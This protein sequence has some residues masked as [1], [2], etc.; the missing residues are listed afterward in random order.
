MKK[1]LI[2]ISV[3]WFSALTNAKNFTYEINS[4]E[5]LYVQ[6]N[7]NVAL[8]FINSYVKFL[9]I[10][11]PDRKKINSWIANNKM[12]TQNFKTAYKKIGNVDFD[13]I[14]DA[15]DYPENFEIIKFN[16]KTGIVTVKG[17]NWEDFIVNIKIIKT[18]NTWFVDG[19]GVVN[20]PKNLRAKR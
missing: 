7:K 13:P 12:L 11:P 2:V 16:E 18:G 14:L 19:C 3:I 17:K 8:N 15:Q 20:I 1:I 9:G 6:Q 5:E 4:R 10:L